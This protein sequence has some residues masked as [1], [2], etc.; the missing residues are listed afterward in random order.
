MNKLPIF[1]FKTE[2]ERAKSTQCSIRDLL[3]SRTYDVCSKTINVTVYL[4]IAC[5][6]QLFIYV[7]TV[8]MDRNRV[9]QKRGHMLNSW[10]L[11]RHDFTGNPTPASE[12]WSINFLTDFL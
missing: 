4:F 2:K 3:Q 9:T 10:S 5:Y 6:V 7:I 12:K 1:P 8:R 11:P